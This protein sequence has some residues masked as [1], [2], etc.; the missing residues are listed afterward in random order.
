M[1][2]IIPKMQDFFVVCE[3]SNNIDFLKDSFVNAYD[4][5]GSVMSVWLAI[6]QNYEAYKSG[7]GFYRIKPKN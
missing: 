5:K 7:D 6:T 1:I 2:A 3:D 4:Y